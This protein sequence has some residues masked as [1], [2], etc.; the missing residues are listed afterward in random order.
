MRG[1]VLISAMT[2]LVLAWAS[3]SPGEGPGAGPASLDQVLDAWQT[4]TETFHTLHVTFTRLDKSVAAGL[5]DEYQGRIYLQKPGLACVHFAKVDAATRKAVD[6]ERI[7]FTGE[8][9]RQYDFKTRRIFVF[10]LDRK[11]RGNTDL[12]ATVAFHPFLFGMKAEDARRLYMLTLVGQNGD[13]YLIG[14]H[15][16]PG[17]VAPGFRSAFLQLGKKTLMPERLL[18]VEGNGKDTQD[19]C[20]STITANNPIHPDFFKPLIVKGWSVFE[21]PVAVARP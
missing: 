3:S 4:R 10:P 7:V 17:Q 18:L 16:R 11:E 13:S 20:F 6:H 1:I 8:E 15:P 5:V 14:I 19:Y 21:N 2:T 9:I 12:Q